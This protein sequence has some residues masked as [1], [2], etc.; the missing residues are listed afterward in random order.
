MSECEASVVIGEDV[1]EVIEGMDGN[2]HPKPPSE[3]TSPTTVDML[4]DGGI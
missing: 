3:S 4:H 1:G 2:S